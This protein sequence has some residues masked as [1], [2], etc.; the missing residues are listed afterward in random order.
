MQ[1]CNQKFKYKIMKAEKVKRMKI[2]SF[3]DYAI[4]LLLIASPWLFGM[5]IEEMESKIMITVGL[6]VL[7][8]NFTTNHKFGLA[9]MFRIKTHYKIDLFFGWFLFVSPFLYGFFAATLLPHLL[10]GGLIFANTLFIKVP[11]KIL[12]SQKFA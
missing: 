8:N 6:G 3:A 5:R 1:F 11:V 10:F 7:L 4:S 12:S 9:K 2:H